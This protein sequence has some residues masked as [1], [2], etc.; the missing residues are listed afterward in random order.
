MKSTPYNKKAL[1][2]LSTAIAG[3]D[4]AKEVEQFLKDL[5]T[6]AEMQ[7]LSD[8]WRIVTP[9]LDG[10]SY[11]QIQHETGV[12][13]TTVGRVARSLTFGEGGYQIALDKLNKET[14]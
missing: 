12:S 3:L 4:S 9:I 10:L 7:A 13:V 6:P 1:K 5:C 2:A 11:R 14:K 8:R